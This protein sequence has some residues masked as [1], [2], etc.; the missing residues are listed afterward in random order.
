MNV[1]LVGFDYSTTP[2]EILEACSC[3][4]D[5]ITYYLSKLVTSIFFEEM[6][7]VSTCNRTEWVFCAVDES[8]ALD[9]LLQTI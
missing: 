2:I 4:K 6:V 9:I 7:I 8:K 3:N 1:V 5:D